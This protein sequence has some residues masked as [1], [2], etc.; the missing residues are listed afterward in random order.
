M[1]DDEADAGVKRSKTLPGASVCVPGCGAV[2]TPGKSQ[3]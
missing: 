2:I 1:P 3:T